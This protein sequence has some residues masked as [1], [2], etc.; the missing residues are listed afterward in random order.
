MNWFPGT[1]AEAVNVSK[2]KNAIF[3]VYSEGKL[4]TSCFFFS[5]H[6]FQVLLTL[7]G[8]CVVVE[9]RL[10]RHKN[11]EKLNQI[12]IFCSILVG[13]DEL[14]TA[15]ATLVNDDRIRNKLESDDFVAIKVQSDSEAYTQ[16]AQICEYM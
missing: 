9:T 6:L 12:C 13:P 1:I 15:F 10:R 7:V 3:V 14:S 11:H 2:A 8:R 16:F 4:N 5:F